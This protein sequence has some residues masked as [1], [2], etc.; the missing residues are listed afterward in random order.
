[1]Q[2]VLLIEDNPVIAMA[3]R[4]T[5]EEGGFKVAGI[6]PS[7]R[8]AMEA[9]E[10]RVPDLVICDV[11]LRNSPSGLACLEALAERHRFGIIILSAY[12]RMDC[13]EKIGALQIHEWVA[14]PCHE[15]DLVQAVRTFYAQRRSA[16]T[17]ARVSSS[18]A[19]P[20]HGIVHLSL[21]AAED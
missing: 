19:A 7:C 10:L 18:N 16:S 21:L 3:V 11:E 20:E 8:A 17:D 2:N 6:A 12:E 13:E 5:V 15:S 4:A 14:K 1:M 9:F